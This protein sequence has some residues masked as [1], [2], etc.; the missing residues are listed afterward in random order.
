MNNYVSLHTHTEFSYL[1]G[2]GSAKQ[3]MARAKE[4]GMKAI[5][6][7]DHGRVGGCLEWQR[8]A[9][10]QGITPIFG[11]E[12]YIVVDAN[13]KQKGDKRGHIV[14][15]AKNLKGWQEICR[16]LTKANLDGFYSKPR[17]G[18]NDLLSADL[19]GI[20]ILTACIASFLNL[21]GGVELFKELCINSPK[22]Q[23]YL[24]IM[25]HDFEQQH[26]HNKKI[27]AIHNEFNIPLIATNDCHYINE[28]D[29]ETQEMLLAISTKAKWADKKRFKFSLKGLHLKSAREMQLA[30]RKHCFSTSQIKEA[31]ANTGNVAA[32]C[33]DFR[34]PKQE[35]SLPTPYED[36][37]EN[38]HL[39]TLCTQGFANKELAKGATP[40]KEEKQYE[41]YMARFKK[42]FKLIK[43]K[44]FSK[45]F[46]IF[47]DL[48]NW[49][50]KEGIPV[51]PGRGCFLPDNLIITNNGLKNI[52][53]IRHSDRVL[54][55]NKRWKAVEDLYR[56][57]INEEIIEIE[58]EDGRKISCTKDHKI[59]INKN[60]KN[61]WVR[62]EN[63]NI[64]DN[65]V[66]LRRHDGPTCGSM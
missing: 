18:F 16:L 38:K 1:D 21:P 6:I 17:I 61:I 35:I 40:K 55:H 52:Q 34:I 48:I 64:D 11:V 39:Y 43:S 57:Q 33:S 46:L 3:Y 37:G 13:I 30:F 10:K 24:E 66:D 65:I 14:L 28:D 42:E 31:M 27:L 51:G 8:E 7:T 20:I 25:P 53:D 32:M 63:L 23:I 45:Y 2:V 56:Y 22:G 36:I 9:D 5:A 4:L 15:L 47:H 19:S 29:W 44:N 59:L 49:C 58:T 62:A 60:N 26:E 54:T 50:R 12:A 41:I